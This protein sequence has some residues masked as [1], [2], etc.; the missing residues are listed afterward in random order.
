MAVEMVR[1][2]WILVVFYTQDLGNPDPPN[3]VVL[4]GMGRKLSPHHVPALF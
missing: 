1:S 2:G 3:R 4:L